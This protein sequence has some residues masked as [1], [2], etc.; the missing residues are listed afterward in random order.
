MQ[1]KTFSVPLLG[2]EKLNEELNAFLRSKKV[3]ELD[4][5]L[6]VSNG[7]AFWSFC[8]SYLDEGAI[9]ERAKVDYREVL[10]PESFARFAR[11]RE[12]RKEI[13]K[14]EGTL[15]FA[16]FTD[17]ELAG[18]AK[19]DRLTLQNM[20]SVKGVGEKKVEKYGARFIAE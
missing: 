5:Q 12:I 10:D 1:I 20:Q 15:A 19:I 7:S 18:L 14:E 16:I 6:V 3:L 9:K 11:M 8:V 17:E 2:G 4:K 13:S